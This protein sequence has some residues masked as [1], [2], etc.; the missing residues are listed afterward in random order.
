MKVAV[1]RPEQYIEDTLKLFRNL[2]LDIVPV[3]F[4]EIK[5]ERSGI[6]KMG[7]LEKFDVVIITSQ[8]S[9]KIAVKFREKLKRA[10]II[11]IGKRTAKILSD[12]GLKPEIPDKFDS[13]TVYEKYK[14]SLRGKRVILLRSDKG[15]PILMK[16]SEV[17]EV[18][19]IVLYRIEEKWGKEQ[20]DLI[21]Q[22]AGKDIDMVIFSSS[23]MVRSFFNLAEKMGRLD[24]VLRSLKEM[25]VVAIGPPTAR[26]LE[27]YNVKAEMPEEYTFDGIVKILQSRV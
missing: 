19:E 7:D 21:R 15:D 6:E 4:I 9:A 24:E 16:L 13:K 18:D 26:M 10:R 12:A 11:A 14:E 25:D 22:I 17:A 23:M 1:L 3:P 2:D 27:N 20:E 8:T 5:T